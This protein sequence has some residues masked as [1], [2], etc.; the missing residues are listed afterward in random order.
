LQIIDLRGFFV[1]AIFF[2]K[3]KL[4]VAA[5]FGKER[6]GILHCCVVHF[7]I[8]ENGYIAD[9]APKFM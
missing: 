7:I 8:D 1:I 2:E 3:K 6:F 4:V 5:L 9:A